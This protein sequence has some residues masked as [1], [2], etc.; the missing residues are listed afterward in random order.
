MSGA[1]DLVW[2]ETLKQT[3]RLAK[4]WSHGHPRELSMDVNALTLAVISRAGFG[5]E[6][7]WMS[8][9][10]QERD[11]PKGHKMS[12]L[13]AIS[14]TTSYMVAILVIPGWLLNLTPLRKA[15]AAHKELDK[16]LRELIREEGTRIKASADHESSA[17]RGN[18]LTAVM[19]ASFNE[20]KLNNQFSKMERKEAFTEDEVMGNLF[21]Y[22]LAGTMDFLSFNTGGIER[23]T[24][25]CRLRDHS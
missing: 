9:S 22:L 3:K 23:L 10:E 25:G 4:A 5:K 18:L 13:K 8:N 12:F 17:A 24:P 2:E 7:D 19:R 16:Y 14:D 1:N 6:I 15:H 20:A 21:I 11:L